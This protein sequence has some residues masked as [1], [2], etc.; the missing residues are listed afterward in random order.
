MNKE[1]LFE[2]ID[3]IYSEWHGGELHIGKER[4]ERV[5]EALNQAINFI[6][7][8]TQLPIK[9]EITFDEYLKLKK[10]EH[11]ERGVYKW[12]GSFYNDTYIKKCYEIYK[13]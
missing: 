7:C 13:M 11:T 2:Q 8:S 12:E 4:T 5:K 10:I 3:E 9:D 6:P 1:Q